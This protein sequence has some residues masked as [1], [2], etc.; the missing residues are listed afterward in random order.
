MRDLD[1]R[2]ATRKLLYQ[3]HNGCLNTKIVEE[4]GLWS[5]AVRIDLAVLNGAMSGYEL[6][7]ARDN[8]DRLPYQSEIYSQV[9]DYMTLVIA[10][11]H[12][13]KARQI[14]PSWWGVSIARMV[15]DR[16]ELEARK[17]SRLNP[18]RCPVQIAR[19][20]WRDEAI[21][22]LDKFGL[23]KGYKSKTSEQLSQRL[24][25]QL[26]IDVLADEV[27]ERLK[28]RQGWLG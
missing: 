7:S 4:M 10:E 27:R 16:V 6:K 8:L 22:V 26:P 20:L 12:V 18:K 9:F 25:E 19:L 24:A 11:K 5:G 2:E 1:V 28:S 21:G 15:D 17:A 14:I 13:K 23:L 3:E